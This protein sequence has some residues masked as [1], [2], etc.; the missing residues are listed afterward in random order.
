MLKNNI[1]E[2]FDYIQ[3]NS[4]NFKADIG[5]VLGTG[6]GKLVNDVKIEFEIPY[7]NIPHFPVSTVESHS[8]KLIL[9]TLNSKKVVM[10]QGRFHFYEG[11]SMQQVTFPIRVMKH[12][13]VKNLLISNAC[14]GLNPQFVKGDIAILTDHINLL[15]DNPL[16]GKNLDDFGPR[17]PD[18]SEPYNKNLISKAEK[19][20]INNGFTLKRSVYVAVA[21]PNLETKAEYRFL[22]L[23][24]GDVVGM[25]T[26]PEAIVGIHQGMNIL[27]LGVITDECFPDALKPA[28]VADIIAVAMATEPRLALVI[29]ELV[30]EI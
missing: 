22:R 1:L 17:F 11:Y 16:I 24:G 28:N 3:K 4:A 25:S 10:M 20:A 9:G 15:G 23:I 13:G 30:S 26:V 12:L 18:M 2:A 29:R 5:I 8:G 27:G 19:I 14:G 21:G 7:E 6:L